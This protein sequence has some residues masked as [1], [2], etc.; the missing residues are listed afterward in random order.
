M[1]LCHNTLNSTI[2]S[3]VQV[4]WSAP[5]LIKSYFKALLLHFRLHLW[6]SLVWFCASI[7][8]YLN[9]LSLEQWNQ[10]QY[11]KK[12]SRTGLDTS[13]T[14]YS[15]TSLPDPYTFRAWPFHFLCIPFIQLFFQQIC[16]AYF[17]CARHS[18]VCWGYSSTYNKH[19]A[20]LWNLRSSK[21]RWC[22]TANYVVN[23]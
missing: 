1:L 14:A 20:S 16:T 19:G 18:A 4:L 23:F 13:F 10:A 21:E 9:W 6:I 8:N 7:L 2:W 3:Y 22:Q 17:L 15:H 12:W 5:S 11:R